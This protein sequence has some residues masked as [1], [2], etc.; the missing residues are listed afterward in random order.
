[1][2]IWQRIKNVFVSQVSAVGTEKTYTMNRKQ[3]RAQAAI[4]KKRRQRD[5]VPRPK[6]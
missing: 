3:R 2:K 6:G 5:S 1:M 4:E